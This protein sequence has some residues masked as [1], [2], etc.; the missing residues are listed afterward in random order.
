MG[1]D[2]QYRD[3]SNAIIEKL[4]GKENITGV[5]HCATRLRILV[6][7]VSGIKVEELENID[8][9]KGAFIVGNQVQI[10]FGAGIVNEVYQVFAKITGQENMSLSDIKE[11]DLKNQNFL[12]NVI[13]TLS[14]VFVPIIPAILAAAILMGL[15]GVLGKSEAVL[16]N[17]FLYALNRLAA[18]AS[19]AIFIILP[20]VVCYSATIKF[21]G[22]PIVGLV[23][24]AIMI[25]G[26]LANAYSVG[27]A[28]F[29][30]EI[31]NLLGLKI[32]MV[33]F[34]GSIIVALLMGFVVATLDKF[35]EK[36]IPSVVKF[37]L[38]SMLT[39]FISTILLFVIVG[40]F[41]RALSDFI[42]NGLLWTT[43]NLGVVGYMLFA[44]L[45]QVIVITGLHHILN[46]VEATLIAETGF[47][48]LNPLMSVALMAQGG[49]VI[50]YYLLNRKDKRV[51]DISIPAFVSILFGI[52]E[53]AIFGINLR[54]K[55]PLVAGCIA[56]SIS[57]AYVYFSKL[58]SIGFGATALPG[59]AIASPDNNGYLNYV[60]AHSIALVLGIIFTIIFATFNK[61]E[62]KVE[63]KSE[64]VSLSSP[65]KG[66]V[67]NVKESSDATF[68]SE[69]LGKGVVI[70]PTENITYAPADLV[71]EFVY[72]TKHALGLKFNDGSKALLHI[73]IDTVKMEGNGFNSFVKDGDVVKKG[74]KLVEFDI[75][76]IVEA[77]Y[78]TET[79]FVITEVGSGKTVEIDPTKE[80]IINI[81]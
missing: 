51:K 4:S 7:D 1:K 58:V 44:G 81:K 12:Q 56:A 38:S 54:Y 53:P 67:K 70:F 57:G 73:G 35:F 14:D 18:L 49:A 27:S 45:Q 9:V 72:P 66:E 10:I 65:L 6:S 30:P 50:G 71:V 19:T 3:I 47:N 76:K 16:N 17:E 43:E 40:P 48:F 20:M 28:N 22:R 77:G 79:V 34:Q 13:K 31:L 2:K 21:G 68:A 55:F 23:V 33:G 62:V 59:F 32:E 29:N 52:S 26:S 8:L 69:V 78:K 25:D 61:K 41:G 24:G 80:S 75:D 39:V 63:S 5:A 42:V 15:T 36:R 46:A 11:L 37:L 60:I 64:V 74:T